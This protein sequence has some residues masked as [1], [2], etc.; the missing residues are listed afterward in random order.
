MIE[1]P[2]TNPGSGGCYSGGNFGVLTLPPS[3]Q[4][5]IMTTPYPSPQKYNIDEQK[6]KEMLFNRKKK[7]ASEIQAAVDLQKELDT[8]VESKE[9][10]IWVD[11]FK[12]T[13]SNM[14]CTPPSGNKFQY[15]LGENYVYDGEVVLCKSGFHLC[16]N[17]KDVKEYYK[18][19]IDATNMTRYFVCKAL[20]RKAD[21]EQYGKEIPDRTAYRGVRVIDKLTAKEI[22]LVREL[23]DDEYYQ[24]V[25]GTYCFVNSPND[26]RT[27]KEIGYSAYAT[28]KFLTIMSEN[29]Y[30]DTFAR[31]M[32]D[33]HYG[34]SG[35][36]RLYEFMK[37]AVA[38]T[39]EN[40][41]TDMR[42]YLLMK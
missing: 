1:Y 14:V 8:I 6:E 4:Y 13:D 42:I 35:T 40:V 2:C 28:K 31:L 34:N 10:W 33:K 3:P 17:M 38:L 41:S 15:A 16:L 23:T 37:T 7:E 26:Y 39:D 18:F 36:K 20:V 32:L 5:Q 25:V 30:S 22:T 24:D 11:G 21:Y 12:G 9:E 19:D 27:I 29:G